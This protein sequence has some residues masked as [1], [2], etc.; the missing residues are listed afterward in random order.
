MSS[1]AH[2]L[3]VGSA[4]VSAAILIGLSV[5]A[6]RAVFHFG[7]PARSR[8]ALQPPGELKLIPPRVDVADIEIV[9][10]ANP[11]VVSGVVRNN[12]GQELRSAEVTYELVAADGSL[13]SADTADVTG[14]KP[15]S[16]ASFRV[17]LKSPQAEFIIVRDVRAQ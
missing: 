10:D 2:K 5:F 14:L 6:A 4:A 11:P 15:H 16:S 12:T 7:K 8:A 3:K 17:P 9:R 1:R 13:L